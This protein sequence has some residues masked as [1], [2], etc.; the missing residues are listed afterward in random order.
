MRVDFQIIELEAMLA[1][2]AAIREATRRY[3]PWL[4]QTLHQL[5]DPLP[6]SELEQI[7]SQWREH[8]RPYRDNP[9]WADV[10]IVE[11]SARQPATRRRRRRHTDQPPPPAGP[12]TPK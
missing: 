2:T 1:P 9:K 11:P 3:K 8:R 7:V 5:N 6:V 10:L 12:P 4:E